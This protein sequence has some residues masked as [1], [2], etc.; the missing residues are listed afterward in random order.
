[1][2]PSPR[3][4]GEL[5]ANVRQLKQAIPP[6]PTSLFSGRGVVMI[7]GGMKY[8][9][10]G[11][12]GPAW[13]CCCG[14]GSTSRG[15]GGTVN[16][17]MGAVAV[18][19]SG[20]EGCQCA[21]LVWSITPPLCNPPCLCANEPTCIHCNTPTPCAQHKLCDLGGRV[22]P[23]VL[24]TRCG[25]CTHTTY[26]PAHTTHYTQNLHTRPNTHTHDLY[27]PG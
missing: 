16:L 15:M 1:M 11:G 19:A 25:V 24:G 26:C 3:Q 10:G 7:A 17:G 22:A 27:L 6:Y 20:E 9:V 14:L 23:C 21:C 2:P 18:G 12:V 13:G 4:V 5:R 8:M